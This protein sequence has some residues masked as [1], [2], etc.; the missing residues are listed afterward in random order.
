MWFDNLIVIPWEVEVLKEQ[1]QHLV[2]ENERLQSI[3]RLLKK[4]K[5]GSKAECFE[6]IT[7]QLV[8]NEIEVEAPKAPP[9]TEE[10]TYTRKKGRGKKKP[11]P[12]GVPREEKIIDIPEE[13]KVCPHDG[14][15]LECIGEV[16]TEKLKTISKPLS[17]LK[18]DSSMHVRPVKTT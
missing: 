7:D 1:S 4:D 3:I 18:S 6:E 8:F 14:S 11:I 13:E 10:I 9:E 15:R 2:E 12:D 5:F 16:V 17:L